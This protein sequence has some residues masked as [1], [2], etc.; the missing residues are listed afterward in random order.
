[1]K[2]SESLSQQPAAVAE[3][4]QVIVEAG[5]SR[6]F[7]FWKPD[8]RYFLE[9]RCAVYWRTVRRLAQQNYLEDD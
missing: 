5:A 8:A 7:I 6:L 4:R 3:D 9:A 1:M 2:T